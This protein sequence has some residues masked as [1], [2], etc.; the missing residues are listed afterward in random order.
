MGGCPWELKNW[1]REKLA[2]GGFFFA[3]P[4]QKARC[5]Q[6]LLPPPSMPVDVARWPMAAYL[7]TDPHWGHAGQDL[8]DRVFAVHRLQYSSGEDGVTACGERIPSSEVDVNIVSFQP[9]IF[10]WSPRP[11]PNPVANLPTVTAEIC[12]RQPRHRLS[13]SIPATRNHRPSFYTKP[14]AP[15]IFLGT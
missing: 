5:C 7:G 12:D 14:Y 10:S 6:I 13:L 9:P 8:H 2:C 1:Q 3:D 11:Q 15:D 4:L